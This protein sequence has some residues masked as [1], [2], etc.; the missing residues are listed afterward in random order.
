MPIKPEDVGAAKLK[1]LPPEVIES[2]NELIARNFSSGSA[3]VLQKDVVSS[4]VCKGF[5]SEDIFE[6]HWLDVEEIFEKNGWK[7]SYDKPGYNESYDASF[8]FSVKKR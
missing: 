6:N 3:T 2:F 7:V 8:M 1:H 5:K 4:L